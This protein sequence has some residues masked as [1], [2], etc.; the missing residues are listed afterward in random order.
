MSGAMT[1]EDFACK[2]SKTIQV[3]NCACICTAKP[4]AQHSPSDKFHHVLCRRWWLHFIPAARCSDHGV[5][6]LY[7]HRTWRTLKYHGFACAEAWPVST[8]STE[9]SILTLEEICWVIARQLP[10]ARVVPLSWW[11]G[12]SPLNSQPRIEGLMEAAA[13]WAGQSRDIGTNN[14]CCSDTT[15]VQFLKATLP[16]SNGHRC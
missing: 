10:F 12:L 2:T 16:R 4:M 3:V 13:V 9:C 1:I 15:Y 14:C 5:C 7:N 11:C 6:V 8:C